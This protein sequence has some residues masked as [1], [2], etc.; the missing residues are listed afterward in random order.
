LHISKF[1]CIIL[2]ERIEMAGNPAE[3][4]ITSIFNSETI[5]EPYRC[6]NLLGV[7]VWSLKRRAI[8]YFLCSFLVWDEPESTRHVGHNLAYCTSPG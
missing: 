7:F 5:Q 2:S 8:S 3:I 6:F 4:K 1:S